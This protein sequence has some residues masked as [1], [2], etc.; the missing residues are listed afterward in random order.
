M[1]PLTWKAVHSLLH[2]PSGPCISLF[3]PTHRHAA[4]H[5]QDRIV[6]RNLIREAE[7]QLRQKFPGQSPGPLLEPLQALVEDSFFWQHALDGLAILRNETR[8]DVY[9]L[10]RVLR[11]LVV[12]TNSYHVKPLVRYLQSADRYQV[13][14]L[15]R[16]R[17]WLAEG[18]RY[19]L[20]LIDLQDMPA[21]LSAAL[22]DQV[23]EP[24]RA[25][26]SSG[27]GGTPL[28]YGQGSRKDEIENDT[29]RFFR[30]IDREVFERFSQPS[31]LPLVLV[32]LPEQQGHFRPLSQNPHLLPDGVP[33]NPD[34]RS[35]E[36][37]G[38]EVW[39]VIEPMYLARLDRLCNDFHTAQAHAKGS[40]DLADVA[41]AVAAGRVGT[42]LVEAFRHLP[43]RLDR[44]T[45]AIEVGDPASPESGD[46]LDDVAEEVLRHGGEVVVVPKERMPTTTGL[47]ATYRF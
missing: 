24:Q 40:A 27:A 10:P 22:G 12:V 31:G 16:D 20:E 25:A 19:G 43:G 32:G 39:K 9:Q 1:K 14:A 34:A 35:L 44:A 28:H 33:I 7:Q 41:R 45:G 17:A 38:R 8:F 29:L 37:L 42:L 13:L 5:Q 11:S 23:T 21:T 36:E 2:E 4:D 15:T 26:R 30:A 18:N 47:V 46:L 3:Q 6:L